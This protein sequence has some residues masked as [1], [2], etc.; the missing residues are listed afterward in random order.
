MSTHTP[1]NPRAELGVERRLQAAAGASA[2][3]VLLLT[4]AAA[5]AAASPAVRA[6]VV[7]GTLRVYGGSDN[8]SVDPAANGLIQVSVQ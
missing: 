3:A 4:I 8:V 1:S 7:D 5:P 6:R 2:L